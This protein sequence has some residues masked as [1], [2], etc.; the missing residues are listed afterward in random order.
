MQKKN[1]TLIKDVLKGEKTEKSIKIRGWIYRTRSSGNIVF[2]TL[3]DSS[4]ILQTTVKKGNLADEKFEDAEKALIES[5]I[6]LVGIVK[7]D[8]RAPG[9]FELQVS[10]LKIINF[11][12][13]QSNNML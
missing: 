12:E 1:W 10:D 13:Q 3:R 11:A 6:E 5:S 2:I 4:G 7:E 8:K 9:G